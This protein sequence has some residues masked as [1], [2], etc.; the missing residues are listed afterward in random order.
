MFSIHPY[1]F[2]GIWVFDN[3]ARNLDKE[4]FVQGADKILDYI[5]K[6]IAGAADGFMLTFSP[7]PVKGSKFVVSF[8]KAEFGGSWYQLEG[9]DIQGWLCPALFKFFDTAPAKLF[10]TVE[11]DCLYN[12]WVNKFNKMFSRKKPNV[13]PSEL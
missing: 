7:F 13:M 6:D 1:K 8:L 3:P 12:R 9:T 5:S 11:E 2:K 4:A 10:L